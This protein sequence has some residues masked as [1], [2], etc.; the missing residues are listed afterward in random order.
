MRDD[1]ILLNIEN[2]FSSLVLRSPAHRLLSDNRMLISFSGRSTG[3]MMNIPVNYVD[4]DG[5]ILVASLRERSWWKN[6]RN[7]APATITLQGKKVDTWAETI[8][9]PDQVLMLFEKYLHSSPKFAKNLGFDDPSQLSKRNH[10][11]A[12]SASKYVMLR[13]KR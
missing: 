10:L 2:A 6:L 1:N 7:G 9:D 11:F 4:A 5:E 3:E 12:N 13:F 8:E